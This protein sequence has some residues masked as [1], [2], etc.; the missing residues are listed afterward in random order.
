MNF[1][2]RYFIRLSVLIVI[3]AI[4]K[5]LSNFSLVNNV[6]KHNN[7][8]ET[9]SDIKKYLFIKIENLFFS[10]LIFSYLN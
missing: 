4:N 7:I 1:K 5:N 6:N 2:E 10:I 9:S 8:T 3:A